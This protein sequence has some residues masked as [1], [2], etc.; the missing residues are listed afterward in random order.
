[1][2]ATAMCALIAALAIAGVPPL[3]GFASKWLMYATAILGGSAF[4][5]FAV[6][7]I[8]AMF[9]SLVTLASFL[10]YLGSAFLGP[11]S[12]LTG[13]REVPGGH[14]GPPGVPGAGLRGVRP[15]ARPGRSGSCTGR[16]RGCR[17]PHPCRAWSRCSGRGPG[18][19]VGSDVV[20]RGVL[21]AAA[22]RGGPRAARFRRVLHPARR[23]R[24]RPRRPRLDVRRGGGAGAVALPRRQ[25]LPPVQARLPGDLPEHPLAGAGVP[26]AGCAASSTSMPGST[27]RPR[28]RS[29]A[30]RGG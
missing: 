13:V 4:P 10:K 15:R 8:V 1:M 2:P 11:P 21:G 27:C 17:Q 24:P 28:A 5:L 19:Q 26:C 25:P 3:N 6:L 14:A 20:R 12:P 22:D 18:L 9:I 23:G 30:E 7:G 29:K 16:W